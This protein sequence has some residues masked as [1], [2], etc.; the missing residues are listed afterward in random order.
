MKHR[1]IIS[2]FV[3]LFLIGLG[4]TW[5]G[6]TKPDPRDLSY[7][8]R[9]AS[10]KDWAGEAAQNKAEAQFLLGLTLIRTNLTKFIDRVP[11]LSSVPFIGKRW[12][13]EM[14]YDIDKNIGQEQLA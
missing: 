2:I 8:A 11:V 7:W 13:E 6:S 9:A 12:F 3:G 4:V 5:V 14:S 1:I 10:D